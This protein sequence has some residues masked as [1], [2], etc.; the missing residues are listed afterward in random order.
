[1]LVVEV[2]RPRHVA[3]AKQPVLLSELQDFTDQFRRLYPPFWWDSDAT[4][5]V[6]PGL[7]LRNIEWWGPAPTEEAIKVD[8]WLPAKSG[9]DDA[10]SR[11]ISSAKKHFDSFTRVGAEPPLFSHW[12]WLFGKTIRPAQSQEH[13]HGDKD[14]VI[15][16]LFVQQL[17]DER[18]PVMSYFAVDDPSEVTEGDHD[19]LTF[20]DA[21]GTDPFPY[22]KEFLEERRA[23][24]SYDRFA[25]YDTRYF[26][27][28][29]GFSMIG[30]AKDDLYQSHLLQ[31]FSR[32][33]F[34][35][36]LIAH[37]QRAALLY[38]A[39]EL[40][41]SIK[42]L[43]GKSLGDELDSPEFRKR[44][45][46]IQHR[47]LK[48]RSRAFFPEVTNQLQGREL[49]QLWFDVLETRQLFDQVDSTSER[50]TTVLA[51]RESRQ[52]T[53][54]A[55]RSIPLG[56]GLAAAAALLSAKD[57]ISPKNWGGPPDL[58]FWLIVL[59]SLIVGGIFHC[60]LAGSEEHPWW[61]RILQCPKQIWSQITRN[62]SQH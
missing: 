26:C 48:F 37:F 22:Q 4:N 19:R 31:H 16:G 58:G 38:F 39:D 59:C 7:C 57:I 21:A 8:H 49:F 47:F 52:L 55:T 23:R 33:Y 13:I 50:M 3:N 34:C 42:D 62:R 46:T 12:Q 25:H 44:Q 1:M 40:T 15:S 2:E 54:V 18:M 36:G 32:H 28:G 24:H 9:S 60:L 17:L 20:V 43:A 6:D 5:P 11:K 45:E 29:Y 27:S 10:A 30:S 53:R 35:L 56:I 41:N 14:G 51:E 61:K